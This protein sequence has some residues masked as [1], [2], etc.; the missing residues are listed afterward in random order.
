MCLELEKTKLK[1]LIMWDPKNS[2][3]IWR[4]PCGTISCFIAFILGC[5]LAIIISYFVLMAL[6]L[7]GVVIYNQYDINTGCSFDNPNCTS[8]HFCFKDNGVSMYF[9]CP[10]LGILVFAIL[11]LILFILFII[12]MLLTSCYK[13]YKVASELVE[14]ESKNQTVNIHLSIVNDADM[15][16]LE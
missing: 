3:S 8:T 6:G 7:L 14:S 9:G 10:I 5:S 13:S 11:C 2:N 4:G 1:C 16:E 12:F 15:V